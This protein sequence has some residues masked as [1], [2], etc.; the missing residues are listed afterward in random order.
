MWM[1][2]PNA[3][4]RLI[5]VVDPDT[6]GRRALRQA[7]VRRGFDVV[8][9]GSGL[10]ALELVQ[11]MGDRFRAI[12]LDPDLPEISGL[13]VAETLRQFRPGFPVICVSRAGAALGSERGGG[14]LA[15]PVDEAELALRIEA[16][17][18]GRESNW[19]GG[20]G[21]PDDVAERARARYEATGD[22]VEAAFE[23]ARGMP[24]EP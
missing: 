24:G 15:K 5:L 11:R 17:S 21:A 14:C 13:V 9:A 12:V 6:E 4:S 1:A 10:M 2:G 18:A 8:N 3:E 19:E 22:L 20:S 23:L 16:V 7:L